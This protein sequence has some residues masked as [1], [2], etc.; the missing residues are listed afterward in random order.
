MSFA[1][2]T[3]AGNATR[4]Q[5]MRRFGNVDPEV[6]TRWY[7]IRQWIADDW[8]RFVLPDRLQSAART[9]LEGGP[10]LRERDRDAVV[11]HAD[12]LYELFALGAR[13][14]GSKT[15][16]V[17]SADYPHEWDATSALG[18]GRRTT[19]GIGGR[20]RAQRKQAVFRRTDL[21]VP[22]SSWARDCLI[23]YSRIDPERVLL[24]HPGLILDDWPPVNRQE[25]QPGP[26]RLLFVGNDLERK[27]FAMLKDVFDRSFRG[28]CEL[29]VVSRRARE[30]GVRSMPAEG[31]IVHD[32]V[33][34]NSGDLIRLYG[35]ADIFVMPSHGELS[36][37]V[38]L[39][40]AA[41]SLPMIGTRVGGI[42]DVIRDGSTGRLITVGDHA[43][44]RAALNE[45]VNSRATRLAMGEAAR[46]LV[47]D[48]YD[49]RRN[50]QALLDRIKELVD[51]RRAA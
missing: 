21:F 19:K 39:E 49:A 9:L 4:L 28:R 48:C 35:E 7:P 38:F 24:L 12:E 34:R 16:L 31:L 10:L 47:E 46:G 27:G 5:N 23:E 17:E 14:T 2:S 20:L 1:L 32:Q 29:H 41:S 8:L 30:F 18:Y 51:R 13:L 25:R 43:G 15:V 37:W 22:W 36:P 44:L 3:I 11:F 50:M 6:S 40:A 45:L 26:V 33:D 42:P